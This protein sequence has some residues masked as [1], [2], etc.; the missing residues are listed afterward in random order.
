[1]I[2]HWERLSDIYNMDRA[3]DI[4]KQGRMVTA[5]TKIVIYFWGGGLDC[6]GSIFYNE[7]MHRRNVPPG[8]G[9]TDG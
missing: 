6:G 9:G 3:L 2:V 8:R 7:H 1:M 5:K 4:E